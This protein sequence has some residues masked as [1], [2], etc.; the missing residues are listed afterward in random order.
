[1]M[2]S[3]FSLRKKVIASQT[4]FAWLQKSIRLQQS[5]YKMAILCQVQETLGKF[6][7]HHV[8]QWVLE[9][10]ETKGNQWS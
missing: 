7:K 6:S 5:E 3:G 2:I 4:F 8:F 9:I 10:D 1:M